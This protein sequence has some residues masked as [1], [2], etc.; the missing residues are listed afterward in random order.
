MSRRLDE[1]DQRILYRLMED[2]RNTSAPD[3]AEELGVSAGTI[4]NRI[5]R[6]VE[7]GI[8]TSFTVGVDFERVGNRLT[9]LYTCTAPVPDRAALAA[10]AQRIPGVVNVRELMSGRDNVH[11]VAVGTDMEDLTRIARA[12]SSLGLTVEREDLVQRETVE[13]YA[14]FGPGDDRGQSLA[15]FISLAGNAQVAELTVT[16]DAPLA[17]TTLQAAKREGFLDGDALVVAIERDGDIITAAG[18]TELEA[19]DV[20]T[21]F[22]KAELDPESLQ[23]FQPAG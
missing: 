22:S 11:V 3:M 14:P 19:G 12:L 9:N 13:P 23:G 18:E 6:L 1:I 15:D 4:R 17:G 8:V 16:E 10:K 5:G 2:S 7:D 21:L 20:V